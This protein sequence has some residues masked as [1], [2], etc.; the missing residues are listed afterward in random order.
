MLTFIVVICALTACLVFW[1][2]ILVKLNNL[3]LAKQAELQTKQS[4]KEQIK[5]LG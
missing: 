1:V 3:S 5:L 2:W 4:E